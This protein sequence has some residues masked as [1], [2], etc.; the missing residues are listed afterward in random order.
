MNKTVLVK[1]N[2]NKKQFD[3]IITSNGLKENYEYSKIFYQEMKNSEDNTERLIYQLFGDITSYHLDLDSKGIPYGPYLITKD[4]RSPSIEDLNEEELSFLDD[5]IE[6]I[7]N[8]EIKARVADVLWIRKRNYQKAMIACNAYLQAY[9]QMVKPESWNSSTQ[10]LERA[11]QLSKLFRKGKTKENIL[12][13][14]DKEIEK[15]SNEKKSLF[16]HHLVELMLKI[17]KS[18]FTKYAEILKKTAQSLEKEKDWR[19]SGEY[20]N[21]CSEC[22]RYDKNLVER[23]QAKEAYGNTYVMLA[24]EAIHNNDTPIYAVASVHLNNAIEIY[25]RIETAKDIVKK[26]HI[27]MLEYQ[28]KAVKQM[29]KIEISNIDIS[30]ITQD[31][32]AEVKE[33]SF[34]EKLFILSTHWATLDIKA[35]EE[36]ARKSLKENVL[37]RFLPTV[38]VNSEGKNIHKSSSAYFHDQESAEFKEALKDEMHKQSQIYRQMAVQA[39]IYPIQ[40]QIRSEH[41]F[42][43][44]DLLF[45]VVNNPF[46]P[47]G[48]EQIYAEGLLAGL[49]GDFLISTHLLIPQLENSIRYILANEGEIVSTLNS[50][51]IQEEK[52]L[53]TL[54]YNP[55]LK[56]LLGDTIVFD[57]QGLLVEKSG[58]N[59]RNLVSHGLYNYNEFLS[60]PTIYTWWIIFKICCVCQYNLFK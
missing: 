30:K 23:D 29:Q 5:I 50:E 7:T 60:V 53:N 55:K 33:K 18:N 27:E 40:E 39:M 12:E 41:F 43:L 42:M 44:R 32:I 25:R 49:R 28:K 59:T 46:I 2:F 19:L 4:R 16:L 13:A 8:S 14:L 20:W 24:Y 38:K 48:R 57:L 56:N 10:R 58:H 54:L 37:D 31:V 22:Y 6:E 11:V 17:Q 34:R 36:Q 9:Y 51:G 21:L 35:I 26:L 15:Y 52:N 45:L 47:E 3:E 1:E